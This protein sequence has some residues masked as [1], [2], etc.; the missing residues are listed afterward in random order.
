MRVRV[1]FVFVLKEMGKRTVWKQPTLAATLG[2]AEPRGLYRTLRA[3]GAPRVTRKPVVI[4]LFCGIGGWTEGCRQA[5]FETVLAVDC[6]MRLLKVHKVN[7]PRCTQCAMTLGP[8]SEEDLVRMIR[9][10]VPEGHAF[11]LHASPP[12][13]LLSPSAH[14]KSKP[15]TEQGLKLVLWY[16]KLVMRLR[17]YSW[18]ME[19]APHQQVQG[20]LAMCKALRPEL[21]DFVPAL[22]MGDYGVP[23]RR[24]RCIAGS[25][26]TIA[27]LRANEDLRAPSPTLREV[28]TPPEGATLMMASLGKAADPSKTTRDADGTYRNPGAQPWI[29]TLDQVAFTCMATRP[30]RWCAP[31]FE[32]VRIF[33]VHEQQLLQTFPSSYHIGKGIALPNLGVGNAV[34]PRFSRKFM[35]CVRPRKAPAP[36]STAAEDA[37]VR[38]AA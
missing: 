37:A 7:H 31:D 22:C 32:T 10:H 8:E 30:H 6:D 29:H 2:V 13:Q 1:P 14:V 36:P 35:S 18:S 11:H 27:R 24:R 34:P 23:Q 9:K 12:C 25:P 3:K 4:D 20:A 17:P 19:E 21:I 38:G 15:S 28:L 16:L 5:G 33:T 26:R